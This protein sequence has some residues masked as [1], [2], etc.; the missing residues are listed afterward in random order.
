MQIAKLAS[1][2]VL[3]LLRP[4]L[5]LLGL[6]LGLGALAGNALGQRALGALATT[7]FVRIVQW[8]LLASGVLMIGRVLATAP[9]AA[10]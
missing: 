8:M 4:E 2:L 5:W 9:A 1:F 10:G 3:G 6:L 7:S